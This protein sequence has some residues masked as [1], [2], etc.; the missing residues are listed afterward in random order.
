MQGV[1]ERLTMPS[2]TWLERNRKKKRR[3]RICGCLIALTTTIIIVG[4]VFALMY[5]LKIGLF[6]KHQP[7]NDAEEQY[8]ATQAVNPLGTRD[9]GQDLRRLQRL[10]AGL[11]P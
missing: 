8:S 1:G 2:D 3:T 5:F 6:D 10:M 7:K 4:G 9:L 11:Q